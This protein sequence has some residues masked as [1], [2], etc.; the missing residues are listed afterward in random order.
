MNYKK[1]ILA[2]RL[3][4]KAKEVVFKNFFLAHNS[5]LEQSIDNIIVE[6]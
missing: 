6:Y 5:N 2:A 3:N 4:S 1:M